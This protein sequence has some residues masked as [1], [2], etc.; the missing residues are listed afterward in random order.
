[1]RETLVYVQTATFVGLG[2]L[3]MAQGVW[4][5]GAAQIALGLV[6]WLVYL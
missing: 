5:L 2:A 6:T 4:R 3:L 1:M